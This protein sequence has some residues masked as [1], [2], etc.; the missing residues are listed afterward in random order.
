MDEVEL[1]ARLHILAE[2]HRDLDTAIEALSQIAAVDALQI[3]R[4]KRR[5]LKLKDEIQALNDLL[6]PDIIA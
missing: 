6:L 3:Q 2:E 1:R 5:R 4:L